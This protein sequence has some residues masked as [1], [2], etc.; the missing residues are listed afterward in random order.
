MQLY[1]KQGANKNYH[2]LKA[3]PAGIIALYLVFDSSDLFLSDD[4]IELN[5]NYYT[6][7]PIH[8]IHY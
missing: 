4:M 1:T 5:E 7:L 8:F 2:Q 3:E 6:K